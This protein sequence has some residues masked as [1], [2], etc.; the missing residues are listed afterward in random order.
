MGTGNTTNATS[1]AGTLCGESCQNMEIMRYIMLYHFFGLLW[2]NQ[3]IQGSAILTIAGAVSKWYFAGPH[4]DEEVDRDEDDYNERMSKPLLKSCGRTMR[5][6]IGTV[7]FG[8]FIIASVQFV[9]AIMEYIDA[10]TKTWQ[11]KNKILAFCFK[12][13]KCCLYCFEK[14]IK[15]VS[16][17]AYIT[18]AIKGT[19]FCSSAVASMKLYQREAA[20]IN[21]IYMI[22]QFIL[23][24][25]KLLICLSSGVFTYLWLTYGFTE[26][27][28]SNVAFPI[29]LSQI[30]GYYVAE[31]ILDVY[32]TGIDT[33]L[34][35]YGLDKEHNVASGNTKAGKSLRKFIKKNKEKKA[36]GEEEDDDDDGDMGGD[37]EDS[38]KSSA[39]AVQVALSTTAVVSI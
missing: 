35:C 29:I 37:D 23:T 8:G 16:Q 17:M 7:M 15:Y 22:S 19:S 1:S 30:F 2:T 9:R 18:T 11:E 33:I 34:I 26:E 6:H 32:T 12:I 4:D 27:P 13:V 31:G 21:I 5:Y 10:N 25:S 28:L 24:L 38:G 36:S 3:V 20:L 39:S 14:C